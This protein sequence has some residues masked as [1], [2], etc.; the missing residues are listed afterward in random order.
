MDAIIDCEKNFKFN[1]LYFK[2]PNSVN[3][4]NYFIKIMNG[5]TPLYLQPPKS[6]LKNGIV[7]V[8]KRL[9][10]DLMFTRDDAKFIE[11]IENLENLC[12]ERIFENREKW[13]DCDLTEDDIES[14][15]A[16][17]FKLF[18]SGSF[19]ILRAIIPTLLDKPNI[20]IY[21]EGGDEIQIADIKKNESV[22]TI[23][24]IQGVKCSARSFQLEFIVKQMLSI[25]P[26]D[27]F[28][29]L[30]L[31][32]KNSRIIDTK[33][34]KEEDDTNEDEKE[35][36]DTKDEKEEDDEKDEKDEE[37]DT[38]YEEDDDTKD[39]EASFTIDTADE[40]KSKTTDQYLDFRKDNDELVE[41]DL[42]PSDV[43][44][45]FLKKR[46]DVYYNMYREALKKAKMAK[47]IAL[48]NY[49]EAKRIKNTY[50]LTEL[51]E[52][53]DYDDFDDNDSDVED[54]V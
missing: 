23:L 28:D 49:L 41:I 8:G 13:F 19:Y 7:K 18:K 21:N 39:E 33:D 40:P 46:N 9:Y 52:D 37:D 4:G 20:K 32:N 17:P 48:T 10:S 16:P 53:S 38:K 12:R 50:M 34:E 43:D 27:L 31:T 11:W 15:F 22:V 25:N 30:L 3:G 1:E 26:V 14:S 42:Q 51:N 54:I 6:Q 24:E 47:E 45:F 35:K 44:T 29:R 2:S 5:S 36:D